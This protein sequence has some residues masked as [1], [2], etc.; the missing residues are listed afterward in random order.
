MINVAVEKNNAESPVNVLRRF[1]KRVQGSG[2][3]N[4]VRGIRYSERT[5]SP[6]TRK[7]LAL[8]RLRAR[9]QYDRDVKLG[10]IRP[11][12][13]RAERNER[14]NASA[15]ATSASTSSTATAT[16]TK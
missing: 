5:K 14:S 8:K 3:L 6:Y 12:R 13:E 15:A 7:K 10:K 16:A 1:T 2:I 4:R 11:E 9:E